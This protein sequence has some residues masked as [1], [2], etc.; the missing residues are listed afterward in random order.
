M[1]GGAPYVHIRLVRNEKLDNQSMEI[2]R[3]IVRAYFFARPSVMP[4][5][6]QVTR[7]SSDLGETQISEM[8]IAFI[9]LSPLKDCCT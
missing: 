3:S 2:M 8:S 7:R 5:P 4:D 6:W 9:A 1:N